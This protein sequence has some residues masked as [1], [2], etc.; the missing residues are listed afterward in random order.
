M[1][2]ARQKRSRPV[3]PSL[4]TAH[5]PA[6]T[7]GLNTISAGSAMPPDDCVQLYNL[8]QSEHGLRSRLGSREWVTGMTGLV[9]NQVRSNFYYHGSLKDGTRDRI[10]ACTSTGIWDC[11][12]SSA[13][14]SQVLAF[15]TQTG[16]AGRGVF[17]SYVATAS[18]HLLYC[19]EANGYHV[20]TESS[21]T[22]IA[23]TSGITQAWAA[24]T[25]YVI[26]NQVTNG[27][28]VYLCDT[29]GTS[30]GSGGPTGTGTNIADGSARWDYV[31]AASSTA[32]GLSLAAQTLGQTLSVANLAFVGSWKGRVFLVEKDT[33]NV[34]YLGLNSIYGTATKLDLEFAAKFRHGGALVGVWNWTLDG[35]AGIDD[36]LVFI[37]QGGDVAI[38]AGTSP[39]AAST[40]ALKGT[41][42]VGGI[43]TGRNIATEFGG[44]LLILT[45]AGVKPLSQLI[46]GGDGVGQYATGKISNL[47]NKLMLSKSSVKGWSLH[48][49]P[50]DSSL[51]VTVPTTEGA[52]TEQLAMSLVGGGWSQYRNLSIF[53]A[54]TGGGK[55]YFGTADGKLCI[56]DG[57]VDGITL[58]DV[59]SYTPIQWSCLT[60]F[61]NLGNARLK[62][63]VG[64]K[65]TILSESI[66]PRFSTEARYKYNF[67]E[68][69]TVASGTL[70]ESEWGGG[71][72]DDAVWGG[73]YSASQDLRGATGMGVDVAIAIRGTATSRT[74]LVGIDVGFT[75][76]GALL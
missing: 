28:N 29:S 20:Y 37:S 48:K 2:L 75:Q 16:D 67:T 60:A 61:R 32:V 64:I 53:S 69:A 42:Y 12:A 46:S 65:P 49:H 39:A 23:V 8:I 71:L 40:F 21:D 5:I 22:W 45:K 27:G 14:P 38:Y 1:I 68:L 55:F 10:F 50:E 63:V 17:H 47:F 4:E 44:D 58:A 54:S 13:A 34:Y 43:P 51:I 9:D 41:W 36:Q 26:G 31:S 73:E 30:A 57:Y 70:G 6:P 62:Q 11:T 7:G 35:G 76:G 24:S 18:H 19:D 33:A 59:N 52:A 3:I 15:G 25:A 74:V 66:A 72:W 56:N